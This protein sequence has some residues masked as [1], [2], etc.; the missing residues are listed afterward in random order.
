MRTELIVA[1][2]LVTESCILPDMNVG[3]KTV[4]LPHSDY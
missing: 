4:D 1:E 2:T 3:F